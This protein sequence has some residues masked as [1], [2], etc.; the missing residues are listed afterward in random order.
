MEWQGKTN[1]F[2]ISVNS[3]NELL[4][5]FFERDYLIYNPSSSQ[6]MDNKSWKTW[7]GDV[8]FLKKDFKFNKMTG[9]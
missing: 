4:K 2:H 3:N 7:P 6:F 9:S 5:F 8:I 1:T